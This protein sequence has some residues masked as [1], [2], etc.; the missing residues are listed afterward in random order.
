MPVIGFLDSGSPELKTSNPGNFR[1]PG[2]AERAPKAGNPAGHQRRKRGAAGYTAA[3]AVAAVLRAN[4]MASTVTASAPKRQ[5]RSGAN[6]AHC[7]ECSVL[8]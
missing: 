3:Q 8:A 6:S 1:K 4:G 2:S 7:S 5:L